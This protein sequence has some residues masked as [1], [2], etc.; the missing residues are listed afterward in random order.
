MKQEV[1]AYVQNCDICQKNKAE[2]VPYPGLLQPIHVPKQAW[3]HISMDFIE[4][5]PKSEGYDT[6]LVHQ[7]WTL[8][9]AY[10]SLYS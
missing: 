8:H 1:I 2:H 7:V 6:I 4:K 5:L 9:Q 3:L 10:S